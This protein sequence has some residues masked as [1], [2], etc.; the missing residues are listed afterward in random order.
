MP[1]FYTQMD[2]ESIDSSG[3][4]IRPVKDYIAGTPAQVP[5]SIGERLRLTIGITKTAP[6]V[7]RFRDGQIF[8]FN[9]K[10]FSDQVPSLA[11]EGTGWRITLKQTALSGLVA[12]A[13]LDTGGREANDQNFT[14][15][16][17]AF[18]GSDSIM[19]IVF[20]F[21]VTSDIA[22]WIGFNLITEQLNTNRWTR[23]NRSSDDDL[24]NSQ[25]T[26]FRNLQSWIEV[27]VWE[28]D[29]DMNRFTSGGGT[30]QDA[31]VRDA[32]NQQNE[33][34]FMEVGCK[35]YDQII[36]ANNEWNTIT[37]KDDNWLKSVNIVSGNLGT[38]TQIDQKGYPFDY[39][40][41][42]RNFTF[43][44]G[45]ST[46]QMVINNKGD[47]TVDKNN[48]TIVIGSP[49]YA[50]YTNVICH[51]IRTDA[52]TEI[53]N[54]T[55]T[56][57]L[58]TSNIPKVFPGV[59]ILDG[60]LETPSS[61]SVAAGELT[62]NFVINGEKLQ[63]GGTY[64]MIFVLYKNDLGQD[65]SSSHIAPSTATSLASVGVP[66]VTGFIET[67]NNIYGPTINDLS[68]ANFERVKL[69]IIID[70]NPYGPAATFENDLVAIR[71]RSILLGQ[72]ATL[73][74]VTF[75][76]GV[77]GPGQPI[78]QLV[79]LGGGFWEASAT[80]RSYYAA[81]VTGQSFHTWELV[82]HPQGFNLQNWT[83]KF[84]QIL[85]HRPDDLIRLPN[86]RILDAGPFPGALVEKD[87]ICENVDEFVVVEVEK[88][89]APDAN[90]IA[91]ILQSQPNFLTPTILPAIEEEE[92]YAGNLPQLSST[93]ITQVDAAFS[94]QLDP[95]KAYYTVRVLDLS[96][97]KL[98][99]GLA[100]DI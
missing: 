10:L 1:Y 25:Q 3:A 47:L 31:I 2:L 35:W 46:T 96:S 11:P 93:Q 66:T 45:E 78:I 9:I 87:F 34:F 48:V 44:I 64:H 77:P 26:A 22:D 33:T 24:D 70:S 62:I 99:Y 82:F 85:R 49:V 89:G 54:F 98:L 39:D 73:S 100:E 27:S 74:D 65:F 42:D 40:S 67:Y 18:S 86:M 76:N 21:F 41:V 7:P 61:W 83:G 50:D 16:S 91:M 28:S 5:I 88:N 19:T 94:T 57:Q 51:L 12:T 23:S 14:I 32:L 69:G 52:P 72:N 80:F 60:P 6:P 4:N 38:I 75:P 55:K 90:F 71:L 43:D 68:V 97:G 84:E 53:A 20:D 81:T 30:P 15:Q 8:G 29:E 56:Y 95:D 17:V 36:G 79:D 58:A 92:S 13:I 59:S 37:A 63:T